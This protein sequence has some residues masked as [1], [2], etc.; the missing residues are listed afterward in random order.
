MSTACG[1]AAEQLAQLP[2]QSMAPGRLVLYCQPNLPHIT[3]FHLLG[4][5]AA[6][7]VHRAFSYPHRGP[8]NVRAVGTG[9]VMLQPCLSSHPSPHPSALSPVT[10]LKHFQIK[11]LP[12][13][14]S[15]LYCVHFMS[16]PT[17]L[18]IVC[19][20]VSCS[21]SSAQAACFLYSSLL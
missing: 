14:C 3:K 1:S 8:L 6:L 9:Q 18:E 19:Y 4:L 17:I 16:A 13:L 12:D 11:L 5:P 20:C 7:P 10:V 2:P 21:Q 15:F